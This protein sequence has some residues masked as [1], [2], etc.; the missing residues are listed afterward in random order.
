VRSACT[1]AVVLLA[2]SCDGQG[3]LLGDGSTDP[4]VDD[5]ADTDWCDAYTDTD[6]DT[7]A[8]SI[9]GTSDFDGDTIPNLL[10]DDSD[11]DT[12][13]DSVEAGDDDL[14]TPPVNTDHPADDIPDFLDTDSDED[15]LSDRDERERGTD[16]TSPDT[17]R[18][19]ATDLEEVA[20][21][22]DPLDPT[23][24][25][26]PDDLLL[27]LHY[28]APEHEHRP[29]T[30]TYTGALAADVQAIAED[31]PGDPPDAEYDATAFVKDATPIYG[32]PDAPEGFSH[33]DETF[34]HGV[35]PGTSLTFD[36]DFYNNMMPPYD[37]AR[38]FKLGITCTGDGVTCAPR[39]NVAVIVPTE[40]MEPLP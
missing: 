6:G 11:G 10:D 25:P 27:I 28:M 36:I 20:L 40:S 14:C 8:D 9:E 16:P 17:D 31:E 29:L 19:G 15:E 21:G 13:P 34:F 3:I 7:I 39:F 35:E 1:I 37:H 26:G 5:A 23:S 33:M 22:T 30:L 4:S 24:R 2:A 18:D 32:F 12:I 38:I